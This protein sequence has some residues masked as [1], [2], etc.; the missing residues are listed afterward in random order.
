MHYLKQ[1]P[2][3]F[4]THSIACHCLTMIYDIGLLDAFLDK[5]HVS[6]N[7]IKKNYNFNCVVS[8]L[9][10]LEKSGIVC[11]YENSVRITSFGKGVAEHI[12]L[13]KIF[14]TGYRN[15]IQQGAQ[16]ALSEKEPTYDSIDGKAIAHAATLISEKMIDPLL[17]DEVLAV[18]IPGTIC[19]LGCGE[20]KM[21]SKVCSIS[22]N[23]G[24]GI[25]IN[26]EVITSIRKKLSRDV[27][28]ETGDVSKLDGIWEDVTMLV[29]CHV[30][31]DFDGPNECLKIINST[32]EHFPNLRYFFYIDTVAAET[33]NDEIFPGFDYV[34]GLLDISP[35]TYSETISM[36]EESDYQVMK[37]VKITSLPRTFL[38]V[39][40][41]KMKK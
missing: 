17:I 10:T 33:G 2:I 20:A 30:F 38:W 9:K 18:N 34:H 4:I 12:G 3:D 5:T 37:E 41:P 36:F 13:I 15:L 7:E 11:F 39:L 19:D 8:A 14:F 6:L 28:V 26:A 31:H 25:E 29:Q 23:T 24:L 16:I 32:L 40:T 21:L 27:Q 22:G 35:R 1:K